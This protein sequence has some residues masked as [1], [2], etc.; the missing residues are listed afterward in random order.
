MSESDAKADELVSE[1]S[2]ASTEQ[3]RGIEE[4]NKDVT[5]MDK[6]TQQNAADTEKSASASEEM[7][8]QAEEMKRYVSKLVAMVGGKTRQATAT[9]A[10][11][12]AERPK[13]RSLEK[14]K[15]LQPPKENRL[16]RGKP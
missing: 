12:V 2:A 11:Q 6:V 7:S 3:A 1:I 9:H 4:V 14:R 5:E 13:G 16:L 8:A 10:R 15:P